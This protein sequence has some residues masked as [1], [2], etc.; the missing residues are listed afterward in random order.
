[1][2]DKRAHDDDL[3]GAL[4]RLRLADHKR[5]LQDMLAEERRKNAILKRGILIIYNRK[6][7]EWHRWLQRVRDQVTTR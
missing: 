1:M 3:G 6:M 5:E 2:H 4:K 7:E